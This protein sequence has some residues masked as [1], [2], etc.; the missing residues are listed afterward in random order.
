MFFIF[1]C[2]HTH[3]RTQTPLSSAFLLMKPSTTGSVLLAVLSGIV[4]LFAF[5]AL[6]WLGWRLYLNEMVRRCVFAE[7]VADTIPLERHDEMVAKVQEWMRTTVAADSKVSLAPGYG[8]HLYGLTRLPTPSKLDLNGFTHLLEVDEARGLARVQGNTPMYELLHLLGRRGLSLTV[9]PDLDHLTV[10]GLLSGVG[11]G[12]CSFREGMLYD[13]V[14]SVELLLG[15][16]DVIICE[17]NTGS[18]TELFHTLPGSMATLGY[19]LSAWLRIRPAAPY[20][21]GWTQRFTDMPSFQKELARLSADP[22]VHYLDGVAFG[23]RELVLLAG[24]EVATL[25][26]DA[27][28]RMSTLD[29]PYYEQAR[30]GYDGHFQRLD[31]V[32]R[33]DADGYFTFASYPSILRARWF[34][35]LLF[36]PDIRRG[37]RQR[38]IFT[39]IDQIHGA[40]GDL[41]VPEDRADDFAR[42]YDED[43]GVYPV[44]LCPTRFGDGTPLVNAPSRALDFGMGYGV[45][46]TDEPA[47]EIM[48]R[49]TAKTYELGGDALRYSSDFAPDE[50]WSHYTPEVRASYGRLR[51]KYDPQ[52]RFHSIETKLTRASS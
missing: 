26:A 7:P 39:S 6:L 31:Y 12:A 15:N 19:V 43:I 1:F 9:V 20:V 22:S 16:G 49:V 45:E 14:E 27:P 47:H 4:L 36:T 40:I 50:F 3:I 2:W 29:T 5:L 11:G 32:Y 10:G 23:P 28:L 21:H 35:R 38:R 13:N 33:W 25:P 24:S 8:R 41:L 34:R 30:A 46:K 42:Y 52:G 44:Y 37:S 48:Q 51:D 17:R 18:H